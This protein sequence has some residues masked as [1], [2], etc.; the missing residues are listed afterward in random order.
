MTQE[1]I[2]Q[3]IRNHH[4]FSGLSEKELKLICEKIQILHFQADEVVIKENDACSALYLIQA[5]EIEVR[6]FDANMNDY[7][8]LGTLQTGNVLGELC[9]LDDDSRSASAVA[10]KPSTLLVI[11]LNQLEV[12]A[13]TLFDKMTH[14]FKNKKFRAIQD[15]IQH[16]IARNVSKK[17]RSSND[18][19]VESLHNELASTKARVAMSRFVINSLVLLSIY[20]FLLG[21]LNQWQSL[22]ISTTYVSV[23]LIM[24]FSIPLIYMMKQ[25][26]Y[27]LSTYGITLHRW[28]AVCI[29]AILL[30]IPLL[31]VI[32]AFKLLLIHT[33]ALYAGHPV[34]EVSASLNSVGV[35]LP[36]WHAGLLILL[37][38]A[39]VPFQEL[40]AR[41]ALQS[42]FQELLVGRHK[43]CW[44]I[45]I[46]NL[47]FG[48]T[49]A[50]NSASLGLLAAIPGLYWGWLYSRQKNLIGVILSHIMTGI[51]AFFV[52]G[53]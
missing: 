9:M 15:I 42:S 39:F 30:T 27:P 24:F 21:A 5:G 17:F 23:F 26:G 37:Y 2:L 41:G 7:H 4:L 22:F 11:E 8:R 47:I 1:D 20:I 40:V 19:L 33:T 43:N 35:A 6:K 38:A 32:A 29:E 52:V 49:H 46:S 50:H 36:I 10:I 16:N 51:W 48:A 13:H 31:L 44:A 53:L 12:P 14:Q 45:I 28:R 25:S 34:F 18:L 3:F